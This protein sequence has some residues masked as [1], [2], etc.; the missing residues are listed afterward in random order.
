MAE[1]NQRVYELFGRPVVE[2]FANEYGA[3][4]A[5]DFHPLRVQRC[6]FS[7]LNH[8]MWW[9]GSAAK[10]VKAQRHALAADPASNSADS[11]E[12]SFMSLG[13]Q[14]LNECDALT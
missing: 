10:A 6:I 12:T 8:A 4:L 1:L 9:V 3:R 14:N 11:P 5:R 2:T 7:D 13:S